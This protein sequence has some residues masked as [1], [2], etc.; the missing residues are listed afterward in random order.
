MHK[1]REECGKT[2]VNIVA[3]LMFTCISYFQAC[4]L[5]NSESCVQTKFEKGASDKNEQS[6]LLY[7]IQDIRKR[8]RKK[9]QI[10][11]AKKGTT[12]HTH[13]HTH[14]HTHKQG[15]VTLSIEL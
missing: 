14:T 7:T 4:A 8:I 9:R 12:K 5:W 15:H 13:T 10:N 6:H 1:V 2:G 3:C 11:R